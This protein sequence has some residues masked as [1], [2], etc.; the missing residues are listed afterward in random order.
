MSRNRGV[1]RL[2]LAITTFRW[3]KRHRLR[4]RQYARWK[5]ERTLRMKESGR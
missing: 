3:E 5:I 1:Y 2:E 4:E